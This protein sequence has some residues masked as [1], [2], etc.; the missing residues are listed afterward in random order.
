MKD[1]LSKLLE[2]IKLHN[3]SLSLLAKAYP[4]VVGVD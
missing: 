2:I 3:V 1:N 4:Q